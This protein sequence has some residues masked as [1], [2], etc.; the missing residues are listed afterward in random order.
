M[1][2]ST[3]EKIIDEAALRAL[4]AANLKRLLAERGITQNRLAKTLGVS[5]ATIGSIYHATK[6]PSVLLVAKLAAFFGVTIDELVGVRK[7]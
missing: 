1:A 2:N 5:A 6:T 3:A 4:L 7:R